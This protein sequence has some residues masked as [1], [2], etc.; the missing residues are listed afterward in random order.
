[1]SAPSLRPGMASGMNLLVVTLDTTRA[2][3]LGCYG[4]DRAVTLLLD[5]LSRRSVRFATAVSVAPVTLPRL[6]ASIFTGRYPYQHGVRL[7]AEYRLGSGETT[8]AERLRSRG[9]E[10]AAFVSAFVLDA[11][12]SVST[13]DSTST[14]TAWRPAAAPR[15]RPARSS[16]RPTT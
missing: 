1:M 9:Y 5:A 2:N 14:T 8:L 16:A 7:N 3:A 11:R 10:T 15:S 4:N 6:V 13:R 12:Y